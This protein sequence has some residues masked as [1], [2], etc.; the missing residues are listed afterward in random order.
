MTF[1]VFAVPSDRVEDL[2]KHMT[3]WLG[4]ASGTE[5]RP[6]PQ[7]DPTTPPIPLRPW[8]EPPALADAA[9]VWAALSKTERTLLDR[10]QST[11]MK[12]DNFTPPIFRAEAEVEQLAIMC[13]ASGVIEITQ[14]AGVVENACREAGVESCLEVK[15]VTAVDTTTILFREPARKAFLRLG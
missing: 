2:E 3:A 12:D 7:G 8:P 14:S 9:K 5:W 11:T 4:S 10:L 13:G 15:F 6:A 1:V